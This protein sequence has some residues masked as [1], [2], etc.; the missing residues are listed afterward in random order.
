[1]LRLF[2]ILITFTTLMTGVC[3]NIANAGVGPVVHGDQVRSGRKPL[4]DWLKAE[5]SQT[6]L[7]ARISQMFHH[8]QT[9]TPDSALSDASQTNQQKQNMTSTG[10]AK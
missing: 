9:S 1:M 2:L 6:G 5:S 3:A 7:K 4:P 8:K 10:V